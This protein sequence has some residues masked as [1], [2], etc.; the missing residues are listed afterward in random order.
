MDRKCGVEKLHARSAVT[1]RKWHPASAPERARSGLGRGNTAG[2]TVD[3][4]FES[5]LQ[6]KMRSYRINVNCVWSNWSQL[7][8]HMQRTHTFTEMCGSNNKIHLLRSDCGAWSVGRRDCS[9]SAWS[10]SCGGE[11]SSE[12]S[13]T[14]ATAYAKVTSS[15]MMGA[16]FWLPKCRPRCLHSCNSCSVCCCASVVDALKVATSTF[17][18]SWPVLANESQCDA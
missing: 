8:T 12:L 7:S 6:Q 15:M 13:A 4:V 2:D 5:N 11:A 3:E 14:P 17:W 18:A 10:C 9:L 1:Y 16:A